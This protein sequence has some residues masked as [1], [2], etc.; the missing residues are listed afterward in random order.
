MHPCLLYSYDNTDNI[1]PYSII[2]VLCIIIILY[3]IITALKILLVYYT[4][5]RGVGKH[6]ERGKTKVS[7]QRTR[8]GTQ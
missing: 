5:V 1:I 6:G 7:A 3:N 2:P 8:L 4:T